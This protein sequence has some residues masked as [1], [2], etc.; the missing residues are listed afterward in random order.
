V[1]N[2][3]YT[4]TSAFYIGG[5]TYL[6]STYVVVYIVC[7]SVFI[8]K[9]LVGQVTFV[10]EACLAQVTFVAEACLAR[11]FK[12]GYTTSYNLLYVP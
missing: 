12:N 7:I 10:A 3:I 8:G 5:N 9:S 4:A 11:V 6:I 1:L 2:G